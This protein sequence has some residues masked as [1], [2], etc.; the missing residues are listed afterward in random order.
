MRAILILAAALLGAALAVWMR[1]ERGVDPARLSWVATAHQFGPVSYRDPAGAIS[2]DG[3][4]IAYSEGRFLRVRPRD[5]GPAMEFPPGNTQIRNLAWSPDSRTIITDGA[6]TPASWSTYDRAASTRQA[7]WPSRPDASSL[8]QLAWSSDGRSI[9]G[10]VNGKEGS[11]LWTLSA[12]GATA[13]STRHDKRIASPAWTPGGELACIATVDN[14]A[15]VTIPCGGAPL[16][17]QPDVDAYGPVA[18]S[19]DGQTAYVSLAND[20]GTVDLW[21]LSTSNRDARRLTNFARDTYAPS[22]A[23]DGSVLFKVQSYRTA[24]AMAPADGGPTSP[25]AT[26]QSETPSWD[27]SGRWIGITYGTW[28]RIPDDARYPDIAQDAGIIGVDPEKPAAA[29]S[30]IVHDSPSEDQSLCWSPNGK[31]IAFHSHKEQSDDL[32]L[33]RV[34]GDVQAHRITMLGRGAEAG[35]PRWSKDGRWLLFNGASRQTH[36]TVIYIVEMN[37]DTGEVV[38]AAREVPVQ[39]LD[40]DVFHAEWMDDGSALVAIGKE[41]PGRHVIFTLPREGGTPRVVHRFSSEHDMPGLGAS[42]DGRSVAFVAPA[43]D[44]FF[45]IYRLAIAGGPPVQVTRDPS[46]KT[47]P[48]WSPDGQRIAFTVWNYDAQFWRLGGRA[49]P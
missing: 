44:G 18:F 37:Q 46:N 5:G 13:N 12:D 24:V 43:P 2:P 9:A 39:G 3:Q 47:Q 19:P 27:P 10:I 16:R 38:S 33:R 15:R 29:P 28:R 6:T 7:L 23:S 49:K 42:P 8:R 22:V 1:P 40:I 45:Q 35:W 21:A 31:W 34:S 20:A 11:E 41:G 32:W 25:L 14:H 36:R 48:A 30:E 26:F 4:W 17:S